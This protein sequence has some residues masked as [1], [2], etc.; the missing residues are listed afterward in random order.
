MKPADAIF[1][2][3]KNE[4]KGSIF[5]IRVSGTRTDPKFGLDVRAL[6]KRRG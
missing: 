4:G 6:L 3:P 5:P 1:R 2:K